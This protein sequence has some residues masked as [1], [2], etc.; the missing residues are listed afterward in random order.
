MNPEKEV[1]TFVS[2]NEIRI[3]ND[4]A[5]S[6]V[7]NYPYDKDS[8]PSEITEKCEKSD[9]H[10]IKRS[11]RT[12]EYFSKLSKSLLYNSMVLPPNCR[13]TEKLSR[14]HLFVIEEP[15]CLRT[16]TTTEHILDQYENA[17]GDNKITSEEFPQSFLD[18][19]PS[20]FTVAVP[21]LIF[22]LYI[23]DCKVV[24][25]QVFG[26]VSRLTGLN[27]YLLKV[28]F[29]NIS[30]DQHICFGD[31]LSRKQQSIAKAVEH[32]I[33]VFWGATFNTDYTYNRALYRKEGVPIVSNYFEWHSMSQKDPMFI[34]DVPWIKYDVTLLGQI[35]KFKNH[36]KSSAITGLSFK[37]LEDIF[38]RPINTNK[39]I[40]PFQGS[41]L[42]RELIYDVA[43]GIYIRHNSNNLFIHVGDSF[44]D[45]KGKELFINSF[46]GFD[47]NDNIRYIEV[48]RNDNKKY[49]FKFTSKVADYIYN[50]IEKERFESQATLKNNIIIKPHDILK[51]KT[52]HNNYKYGR[53]EFI[54][55]ARHYGHQVKIGN[56]FYIAENIDAELFDIKEPEY[57]GKKLNTKDK[58]LLTR[59]NENVALF[60]ASLCKYDGLDVNPSGIIY[61]KFNFLDKYAGGNTSLS[62]EKIENKSRGNNTRIYSPEEYYISKD[63]Y[64]RVNRKIYILKEGTKYPKDVI[65]FTKDGVAVEKNY[66]SNHLTEEEVRKFILSDEEFKCQSYDLDLSFKLG[67]KVIGVD[68]INPLE[69]L[70]VKTIIGF[71]IDSSLK[72]LYF[73]LNDKNGKVSEI[74]YYD[75]K[76]ANINVGKIRKITNEFGGIKSG[77]KIISKDTKVAG[78]PKKDVNIIIGFLTDTGTSEPLVL[79]SNCLTLW[80]SDLQKFKIINYKAKGWDKAQHA[81][82]DLSKIKYQAGDFIQGVNDVRTVGGW[83]VW[84]NEASKLRTTPCEY[85]ISYPDSYALD[86]KF[87]TNTLLD[88]IPNPRLT[89]TQIGEMGGYVRGFPNCHGGFTKCEWSNFLIPNEPRSFVN[90]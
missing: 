37:E 41:K 19:K 20:R 33:N 27:E 18:I 86:G 11:L 21:Y 31:E 64:Y 4:F 2:L 39:V 57:Q 50:Q 13:Y 69:M 36:T 30:S 24:C 44:K 34:Y 81:P 89:L 76:T 55:N 52:S 23:E 66:R 43:Q 40:S 59:S 32:G 53:V 38:T 6:L 26:R 71:K 25:G 82:I 49:L 9:A 61:G 60:H 45:D 22:I 28:P 83:F 15:P 68:W 73:V 17:I 1:K 8:L 87:I 62:F 78:F 14:G 56:S 80:F 3:N 5:V 65:F 46:I 47:A 12:N 54:R 70:V 88:V 84:S 77:S 7:S 72:K 51:I 79:C 58:Y 85:L 90:V 35:E 67:D 16:I 42:K 74:E 29:N 63:P 48:I 10:I 75:Y